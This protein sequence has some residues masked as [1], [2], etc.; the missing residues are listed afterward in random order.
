MFWFFLSIKQIP[1]QI[2]FHE[3]KYI[4]LHKKHLFVY[5]ASNYNFMQRIL[6]LRLNVSL[7]HV[8]IRDSLYNGK[9]SQTKQE[10]CTWIQF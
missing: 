1:K 6:I 7:I 4:I 8:G 9:R 3:K 5:I 2:C 10:C